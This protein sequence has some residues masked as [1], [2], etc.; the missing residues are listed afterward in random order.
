ML[1]YLTGQKKPEAKWFVLLSHTYLMLEQNK[2][3]A[4]SMETAAYISKEGKHYFSA[5]I[6]WRQINNFVVALDTRVDEQMGE[7]V[8][9]VVEHLPGHIAAIALKSIKL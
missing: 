1:T 9:A 5:G 2:K 4:Q 8:R 7:T 6:L 3:A